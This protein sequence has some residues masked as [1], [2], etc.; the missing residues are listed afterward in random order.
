MPRRAPAPTTTI[1]VVS[2]THLP[3]GT[4]ELPPTV[5]EHV[6]AADLL[7]HAGDFTSPATVE[8]FRTMG[9]PM[10]AIHGNADEPAVKEDLPA[11]ATVT[12]ADVTIGVVHN[13]GPE[14]GR[15]ARLRRRFPDCRLV[16]FGHSHIPLL[17]GDEE[18]TILNP[19]S[20]A[21]RRRQ[22]H[23]SMALIRI[24]GDRIEVAFVSLDD[25]EGPLPDECIRRAG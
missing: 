14:A 20:A 12:C 6:R 21:D 5:E 22:P 7:I 15:V 18:F 9:P 13:G 17:A 10:V 25:P 8:R 24:T 1:A 19:G 23:H 16:V 2:D 11:T 3:R 4:R